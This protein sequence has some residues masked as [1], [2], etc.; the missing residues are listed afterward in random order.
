MN[1]KRYLR[2]INENDGATLQSA[3][4]LAALLV[5]EFPTI[6]IDAPLSAHPRGGFIL[7]CGFADSEIE[8][9]G[10]FLSNLGWQICF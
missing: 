7:L 8:A 1:K 9:V 4:K 10:R 5:Q 3:Q 2:I 6:T